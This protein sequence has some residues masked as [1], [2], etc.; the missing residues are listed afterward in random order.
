MVPRL[1][2]FDKVTTKRREWLLGNDL[3]DE[4]PNTTLK[5][6]VLASKAFRALLVFS[7]FRAVYGAVILAVTYLLATSGEAPLWASVAFLLTSM[8]V[9][10]VIFRA[11]KRKWP[12]L[13]S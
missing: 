6:R 12:G 1:P 4:T 3:M 8:V 2:F 9:S 7:A 5:R 11:I 10:R 13:F